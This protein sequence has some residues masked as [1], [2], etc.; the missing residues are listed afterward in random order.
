LGTKQETVIKPNSKINEFVVIFFN[1]FLWLLMP[2]L[3]G[4]WRETGNRAER[5]GE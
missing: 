1:D 4:Q 2:L 3:I 5:E